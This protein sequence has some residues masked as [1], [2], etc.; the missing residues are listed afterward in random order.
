MINTSLEYRQRIRGNGRVISPIAN[1][2]FM[3]G[4]ALDLVKSDFMESGLSISDGTCEPNKFEIGTATINQAKLRL[5]NFKGKFDTYDFDGAIIRP[6]IG[7]QL[8]TNT[9]YLPKGVFTATEP[10]AR[11]SV[12]S[13]TAYDNMEKFDRV[14]RPFSGVSY[15][16]GNTMLQLLQAI[17]NYCDVVLATTSFRNST[18]IVERLL[19]AETLTCGDVI[20]YIAQLSG[21]FARCNVNGALE[22]KWYNISVFD[23]EL[24]LD[25]GT[26]DETTESTYQSGDNA[27]GGDFSFS[28][29]TNYDG[30]NFTDLDNFHH[31]YSLGA[32][33]IGTDD[34]VITG[35][36]VKAMGTDENYGETVLFGTE[37][38]ILSIE[39][40]P[41]IIEGKASLVASSIGAAIVGMRFRTCD[42]TTLSDPSIEAGDIAYLTDRKSNTYPILVTNTTFKIGNRQ[43]VSCDAES[44]MKRSAKRFGAETKAIVELRNNFTKQLST[45]ELAQRAFGDLVLHSMGVYPTSVKQ[46][47]GSTIEY[48]HD[49]PLLSESMKVWRQSAGVFSVCND[50]KT[51]TNLGLEPTWRG[52]DADGNIVAAILTAIGINCEWLNVGTELGGFTLNSETLS[53]LMSETF[54]PFTSEDASAIYEHIN[55]HEPL[56]EEQITRY[57]IDGDGQITIYDLVFVNWIRT[58]VISPTVNGTFTINPKSVIETLVIERTSGANDG[59]RTV[60][61]AGNI[62]TDVF[63][64]KKI[65]ASNFIAHFDDVDK[66]FTFNRDVE[67]DG[68]VKASYGMKP[69]TQSQTIHGFRSGT[70]AITGTDSSGWTSIRVNFGTGVY[71]PSTPLMI[72]TQTGS[73]TAEN[74]SATLPDTTGF[75]LNIYGCYGLEIK[76]NWLAICSA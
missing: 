58:N 17:C 62:E 69:S 48:S 52:M 61:G 26:F 21:N 36:Q 50:Y 22:L 2:T 70:A 43:S 32:C 44:P 31:F 24:N 54:G 47:N 23:N 30:G 75:T 12:I 35:I 63:S 6:S 15:S 8:S 68:I 33:S 18:M 28:E 56:T 53:S 46:P 5:N 76:F 3:D 55:S 51:Q 10:R 66:G 13:L 34:V 16:I 60:L 65:V 42:I 40:N 49:M 45:Y 59:A 67:V 37:G 39:D 25:G 20:S 72:L 19:D 71:L 27:D 74:A 1:I 7:L 4:R 64:C 57:D 14:D 73:N 9:E 41:L 38:Y 29:T 11:G